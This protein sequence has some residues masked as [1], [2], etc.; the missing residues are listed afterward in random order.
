MEVPEGMK[1]YYPV[2]VLLLIL[3]KLYGLRQASAR[4][5]KKLLKAF[6]FMNY[7]RN[8]ADP[9]MYF[10]W[11]KGELVIWISWVDDCILAGPKKTT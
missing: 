4:F 11:V 2:I 5:W 10:R 8:Q 1:K 7:T 9:C 3:R 6:R